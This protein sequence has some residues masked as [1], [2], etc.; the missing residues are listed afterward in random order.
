MFGKLIIHQKQNSWCT[1]QLNNHIYSINFQLKFIFTFVSKS[2]VLNIISI[3]TLK[4][5]LFSL[6]LRLK[7]KRK[8][9][10]MLNMNCLLLFL[11]THLVYTINKRLFTPNVKTSWQ[12]KTP[13]LCCGS[14]HAMI[15]LLYR[16]SSCAGIC[17]DN[18]SPK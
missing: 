2:T 6:K 14:L 8:D 7:K 3:W 13:S 11:Y 15:S 1:N 16:I 18:H 5:P 12:I 17:A 9:C 10:L 4:Y